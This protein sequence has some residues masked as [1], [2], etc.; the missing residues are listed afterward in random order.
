VPKCT[1]GGESKSVFAEAFN[2]R[3]KR[4]MWECFT[5]INT[6]RYIDNFDDMMKFYNNGAHSGIKMTPFEAMKDKN[7]LDVLDNMYGRWVFVKKLKA[8]FKVGDY[9]RIARVNDYFII[10]RQ[11]QL[12]L[13]VLDVLFEQDFSESTTQRALSF[14]LEVVETRRQ[15]TTARKKY[16]SNLRWEVYDSRECYSIDNEKQMESKQCNWNSQWKK[17]FFTQQLENERAQKRRSWFRL[18]GCRTTHIQ[19]RLVGRF[20][21]ER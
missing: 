20:N 9:V 10:S 3:L 18:T 14:I 6:R 19:V 17:Y 11:S 12:Y 13:L 4:I 16:R 2:K 21:Q 5:L 7:K 8:K 1:T 15:Q